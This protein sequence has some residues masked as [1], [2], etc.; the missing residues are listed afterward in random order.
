MSRPSAD[1][2]ALIEVLDR[3][4][5]VIGEDGRATGNPAF[6]ALSEDARR[7]ALGGADS[8]DAWRVTTLPSGA[9]LVVEAS[10]P[11]GRLMAQERFLATLSHEIRTPLNGVLGMA[12]L[13]ERS[14]L[15]G[16][17][18]EYLKALRASGE[19]LLGL[20]NDVLDYAKLDSGR[21]ELE[22]AP[23]DPERLLQGV[24]EL[25][26]PRAHQGGIEIAW[27]IEA[28]LPPV[29]AD[30]GRLR[31]IL[32]NLAGNAV[33]MTKTGGVLLTAERRPAPQNALAGE[34]RLRFTVKDS[35]PGLAPE[36]Q[37]RVFEDFVQTKAG[38]EAGGAG[39][40]LAI[41]KRLVAA[42]GGVVGLD[43]SPGDGAS[44]WFEAAFEPAGPAMPGAELAGRCVAVVSASPI[45]RASAVRQ[46]EASGGKALAFTTIT[47]AAAAAPKG[48]VMLVDPADVSARRTGPAPKDRDCLVM[49][50]PEA[51]GR[52]ARYRAAGYAGYLIKPLRRSSI[53]ARILALSDG[54][55]DHAPV[56]MPVEVDERAAP[57]G[58]CGARVL[59]AED[60]PVNAL[61]ARALLGSEGCTVDRVANGEEALAA[62]AAAPYDLVLMDMRMPGMDGLTATRKLRARGIRT[63][64]VA[65]TA[66]AF[67]ED[68]R[69]CLEAG[70]DDFLTKP[71]EPAAL[72]SALARWTSTK[73]GAKLAS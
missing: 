60:N 67:E 14:R 5:A 72:R 59:L 53:A 13:L 69:A 33:K 18:K 37:A 52:I 58:A 23:T 8:T 55:R 36:A 38:A 57:A 47:E 64:V 21:I 43:S 29:M 10:A 63:P 73:E 27:A 4:A 61:L 46:I 41:V 71:I 56:V 20:V 35:G 34:L 48:A 62:L 7:E 70:M 44:F 6:D 15:D 22:L 12:G 31:Q 2:L 51:R 11:A 1:A 45:V 32:F 9:R 28:G 65:L 40:G 39:L 49:L 42:F 26:S 68:R 30:D 54:D 66:N 17:Q 16:A 19:H 3:A 50:T 24:C 25:L